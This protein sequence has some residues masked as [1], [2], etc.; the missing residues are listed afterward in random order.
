MVIAGSVD[1]CDSEK[2]NAETTIKIRKA[3]NV[4]FSVYASM[5]NL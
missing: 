5:E 2:V 3:T 1:K 4:R